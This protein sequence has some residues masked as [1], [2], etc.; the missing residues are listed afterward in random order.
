M[1]RQVQIAHVIEKLQQLSFEQINEVEDFI[2][3][4]KQKTEDRKQ[5]QNDAENKQVLH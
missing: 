2:D 3:F 4:L 1:N 5:T